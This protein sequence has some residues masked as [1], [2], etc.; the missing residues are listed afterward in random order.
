MIQL[1]Q[2]AG[3]VAAIACEHGV[4]LAQVLPSVLQARPR[5]QYVQLE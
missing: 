5:E 2:A 3:T 1:G 4:T